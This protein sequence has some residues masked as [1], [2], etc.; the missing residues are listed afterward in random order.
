MKKTV[1]LLVIALLVASVA[2]G[3]QKAKKPMISKD[4][5]AGLKGTWVGMLSFGDVVPGGNS[6]AKL[7]ILN[8]TVPVK[9]KLTVENIP[10]I[11]RAELGA[12]GNSLEVE[13]EGGIITSQGTLMFFAPD[14]KNFF[15]VSMRSEKK[16]DGRYYYRGLLGDMILNKK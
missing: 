10:D 14:Q 12:T 2:F 4:N 9:A 11:L 15:E 8:D 13:N 6:P 5:V 16:L 3:A 1:C 7:Q